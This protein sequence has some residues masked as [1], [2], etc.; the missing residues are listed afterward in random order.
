[1]P[2]LSGLRRL[3][4]ETLAIPDLLDE[5]GKQ[6]LALIRERGDE[7]IVGKPDYES[8]NLANA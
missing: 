2:N 4:F 7:K 8:G 3:Q 6:F 5:H 1:M